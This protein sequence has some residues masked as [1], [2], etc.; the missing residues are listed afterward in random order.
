MV[1]KS[2]KNNE[3]EKILKNSIM[4]KKILHS[5]MFIGSKL[6]NKSNMATEFAKHILCIEN[7]DEPCN[8]CK[9]CIEIN[10]GNHPDFQNIKIN[11]EENSIKIEQ[12]RKM[13]EDIIKKPIVS[14]RKVYIIY[15]ADTMT[16]GAQNC[17]L[18]TLEEPPSYATIILLV[19]NENAI[20]NTIKS[21][22]TKVVFT[23]EEE[24]ELTQEQREIY[25]K[26]EEIFG[27]INKYTLLDAIN[28]LDI[29]YKNEK[30]IFDILDFINNIL[31]KNIN[32]N[33]ENARYI[34]YVEDTKQRLKANANYNM[35]IDNLL[36]NIW[37]I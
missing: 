34:E 13:Q 5:Y 9:S 31:Y 22:C 15:D 24:R 37:K 1:N 3:I 17:L 27:N 8:N 19:E 26:L 30:N 28:K 25:L 4:N 7:N 12:I 20:L 35:S 6:S 14:S 32:K 23:D 33:I 29:L 21:R 16:T 18:K 2:M 10:S 36:Y 11:S